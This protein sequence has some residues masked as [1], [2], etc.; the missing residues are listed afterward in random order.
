MAMDGALISEWTNVVR[1]R[2]A[3]SLGV[4]QDMQNFWEAKRKDGRITRAAAFLSATPGDS[5]FQVVEGDFDELSKIVG[6]DDFMKSA[7]AAHAVLD[8]LRRHICVGALDGK[9][10]HEAAAAAKGATASYFRPW[11]EKQREVGVLKK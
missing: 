4:F 6:E 10:T 1:G 5:G 9:G 7:L 11:A 2:E 3:E 8:H